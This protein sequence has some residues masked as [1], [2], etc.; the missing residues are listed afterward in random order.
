MKAN[1]KFLWAMLIMLPLMFVSVAAVA[2]TTA[3]GTVTSSNG[4]P[5]IGVTVLEQGTTN[6]TITDL[7]GK[8][9][10]RVQ[11]GATL[12]FSFMGYERQSQP[13]S[14]NMN[15]VL[16]EDTKALE[17][18]VVVGYGTQRKEAVTGSVAS[19]KGDDM[20]AVAGSN[21]TQ[22]LQG[23]VAGVE[24]TQTSSKPG[25]TMQIRIRGT[26][27]LNASNDPLIVLDGIPFA[28]SLSDINPSDI[29]SL[30]ILKD[31]SATA[32]Y[33]SRGAN[34]VIIITTNRGA[35]GQ[36]A[37][38][39]YNGYYG[40]KTLFAKYPLMDGEKYYKLFQ[41]SPEYTTLGTDEK[42]GVN[43]DWQ[44]LFFDKGMVTSHDITV[45]GGTQASSY[46]F[47]IGYY[48]EEAVV[49]IQDYSR[50]S[51][52][53]SLDQKI[54]KYFKVGFS[55]TN[56]YSFAN[57]CNQMFSILAAT[58][59][60]DPYN[61]DGTLKERINRASGNNYVVTRDVLENLGDKYTNLKKIFGSYNTFYGEAELPYVKGLKYRINVGLNF[62]H[63]N[64]GS[65]TGQ[66]VFSDSPSALSNGSITNELTTN[67]AVEN[68]ITYDK[69]FAEKH[70]LN[71]VAM[72]SAEESLFNSSNVSALD[73]P[74]MFQYWNLGRTDGKITVNPD[75]QGYQKTGLISYMAR[76]M[77][78]YD[79]KYMLSVA[80]RSDGSSR[81]AEGHK[82]HT[83]PAISFG[84]NV[85]NE[86]FMSGVNWLDQL[87]IRV[88]YGETS[89]Q[90]VDPYKTFGR[91]SATPYNFGEDKLTGY[92]ISELPNDEL[93]WEFSSTWN[94]GLDLSFFRNR[95][96][97]TAEYYIMKTKDVLC[98]V[99]M[100]GSSG[101]ASYMDNIGETE[102]KG[103]E[104]NLDGTIINNNNGWSWT[105][106]V[107]MYINRNK[108]VQLASGQKE[109]RANN[110]FVGMPIDCIYD[111][112]YV[113]LW[114]ESDEELR[115]ILEPAATPGSIRVEY[116]GEYENGVPVRAINPDDRIPQSM[117]CDLQ[118]GFNTTVA[119]KNIDLSIVGAYKVGGLLIS[120]LYSSNGY[121][122]T[123]RGRNN[124]IDV[125]YWTP[126]NTGAH[127][128]APTSLQDSN[129]PK[130]GS[131]LGYFDASYLKIRTITLGYNFDQLQAL[132]NVGISK[133]RIYASV[134]NPFVMFSPYKKESGMDPETN[135]YGNEN[136]AVSYGQ[137]RLLTIG[138]NT[139][140]TR[141]YMFGVNFTF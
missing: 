7:E 77:Y 31:A 35:E 85:K 71:F 101:V 51:L 131:T 99:S 104:L 110:W 68:L 109:D 5:L 108:L 48:H 66:G 120:T 73:L 76:L 46:S 125:D 11:S 133:M 91:L 43:T 67:W 2:Q 28:G 56:N 60:I 102:N 49:P 115:K 16:E 118:G 34:G 17:E 79:S 29:K 134:L 19:V 89:N 9:S 10:L 75:N 13:A 136:A 4:E 58:P 100:P 96:N 116:T 22:S 103:F 95:L 18:V 97:V 86:E 14:S 36:K 130:Y 63:Q 139:P 21:I 140:S 126:T 64:R 42:E 93:G 83:Y 1:L 20:R 55:T 92:Y 41:E 8:F 3:S 37:K 61:A 98:S 127:Y 32:I 90:A 80:V 39:S 69:I 26:R 121:L 45:T 105:A 137:K 111:Y 124:N 107:N 94:V 129:N 44:D 74:D 57:D 122:N 123:L 59:L 50:F 47:G 6:G 15:I 38:F 24:M 78:S 132:K 117:E 65:Y 52:R 25:E 53:G 138:T 135:S 30:D 87:K 106:G 23:R 54:G 112:K 70:S 119:W 81:L 141:T 88:G 33:G 128:P 27:S 62:R 72:Y 84:W 12:E 114:Q 113:G 40:V 82:W